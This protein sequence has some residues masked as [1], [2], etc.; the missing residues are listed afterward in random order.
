MTEQEIAKEKRRLF[1]LKNKDH[2]KDKA[3]KYYYDNKEK[4]KKQRKK[5]YLKNKKK[6]TESTRKWR[7]ENPD[8]VEEFNKKNNENRRFSTRQIALEHIVS[9]ITSNKELFDHLAIERRQEVLYYIKQHTDR[10]QD[11]IN[12][13]KRK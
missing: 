13:Y 8:K 9:C 2:I 7:L 5:Y 4:I 1:Y 3:T 11:Q 10:V 12:N 6:F